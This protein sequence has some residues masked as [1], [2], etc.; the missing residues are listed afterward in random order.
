[1]ACPSAQAP[2]VPCSQ[3]VVSISELEEI[4]RISLVEHAKE[5]KRLEHKMTDIDRW[6][7]FGATYPCVPRERVGSVTDG[8]KW[9]AVSRAPAA[10]VRYPH[11][12]LSVLLCACASGLG[13]VTDRSRE[14]TWWWGL[15]HGAQYVP[16]CC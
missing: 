10:G 15:R 12:S 9:C 11:R 7:V 3:I 14:H 4:Y 13:R 16:G 2:R 6:D 5:W 1:M 8:G